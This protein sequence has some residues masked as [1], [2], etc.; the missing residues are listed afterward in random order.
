MAGSAPQRISAVTGSR[1]DFGILR[2]LLDA[3]ATAPEF[4]LEL[5]VTGM[6]LS[7]RFGDT[8]RE[9]EASGLKI[10]GRVD[11][12][13]TGGD[14]AEVARSVG[15]GVA[16]FTDLWRADPP[17]LV[18]LLGDRF[19]TFAAA[20]AAFLLDIPIAH[21]CGGDVTSG[22]HDDGMRHAISKFARLHFTTNQEAS[23]RLIRMGERPETVHTVG[24]P[25][26]DA[27]LALPGLT[28]RELADAVGAD[29]GERLLLVTFHPATADKGDPVGQL[30]E[31]LAALSNLPADCRFLA[32]YANAD[33][34]GAALN[35]ALDAAAKADARLIARPSLGQRLYF[36]AMRHAAMVVGNSSSGLYEAPS[37]GV[38]TVNIG[39]RQ[40][41]RLRAA[42]VIDCPPERAAIAEAMA[43][44]FAKDCRGTVNPYGDGRAAG[45][46]VAILRSAGRFADLP[47]KR[48]YDGG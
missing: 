1:A 29:L 4:T 36:A 6:H 26:L 40:D 41:G 3:L 15:L 48:F 45:R 18:L 8:V 44:A 19:E 27:I 47:M 7:P 20:T 33:A 10:A 2:P 43:L 42:S 22:S 11:C 25:A 39:S 38:P 28:R 9:V 16:G 46:I 37:F 32:T 23:R 34:G 13:A 5:A 24:S 31:L 12:E 21:L 14:R 35:A 17:D 30:G